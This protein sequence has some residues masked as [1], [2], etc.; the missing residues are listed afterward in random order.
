MTVCDPGRHF[1]ERRNRPG[2]DRPPPDLRPP[3]DHDRSGHPAARPRQPA[4]PSQVVQGPF[5]PVA[6]QRGGRPVRPGRGRRGGELHRPVPDGRRHPP[7]PG[8]RRPGGGHPGRGR[9]GLRLPGH[10]AGL[11]RPPRAPGPGAEPGLGRRQRVHERDRGR[12]G[13]AEPGHLGHA[14]GR[15]RPGQRHPH[16]GHPRPPPAAG[17]RRGHPAG[18]PRR[19]DPVAAAPGPGAG[20]DPG[21]V[22]RLGA[23]GMPGRPRPPRP[24][25]PGRRPAP[26][27][28]GRRP[29]PAGSFPWSPNGTGLSPPSRWIASPRSAPPWPPRPTCNPGAARAALRKA[30]LSAR[31][32]DPS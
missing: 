4:C 30:V 2:H 10:R 9:A 7:P 12:A 3:G 6:A 32:G 17:R 24:G 11:A 26:A 14:A 15:L 29:R 8:G 27:S 13:L 18:H 22:P 28:R 21:R 19:P 31:N 25:I 23:G 16:H 20:L 1:P 5:G